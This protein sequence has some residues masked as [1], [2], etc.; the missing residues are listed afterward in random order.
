MAKA[1][2]ELLYLNADPLGHEK[3]A[4]LMYEDQKAK[5]Y[6]KQN[7]GNNDSYRSLW[8]TIRMMP[9]RCGLVPAPHARPRS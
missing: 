6:E 9:G 4:K 7:H 5:A 3:V 8:C 1:D 2:G